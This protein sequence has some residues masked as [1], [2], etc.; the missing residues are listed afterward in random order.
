MAPETVRTAIGFLVASGLLIDTGKKGGETRQVTI[1]RLPGTDVK[2][3]AVTPPLKGPAKGHQRGTKEVAAATPNN[4]QGTKEQNADEFKTLSNS[5]PAAPSNAS[6]SSPFVEGHR[7]HESTPSG[8]NTLSGV[9][10][11]RAS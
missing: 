10:A 7:S 5:I 6:T 4:E 1:Y 2:G 3:V 11:K 8:R 9:E